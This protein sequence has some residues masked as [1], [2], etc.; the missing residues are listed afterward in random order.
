M[1]KKRFCHG[2]EEEKAQARIA[3][4]HDDLFNLEDK[5][6]SCIYDPD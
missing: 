5:K 3:Q 1:A 2:E 4:I 6:K